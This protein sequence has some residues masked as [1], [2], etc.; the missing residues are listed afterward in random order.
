MS[1]IGA[2]HLQMEN[3]AGVARNCP[4]PLLACESIDSKAPLG[5]F[6]VGGL[7]AKIAWPFHI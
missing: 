3:S 2:A 5:L 7:G 1:D 6:R 4:E